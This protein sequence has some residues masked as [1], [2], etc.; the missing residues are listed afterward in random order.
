MI[1]WETWSFS[2]RQ[3][4][5]RSSQISTYTLTARD[6]LIDSRCSPRPIRCGRQSRGGL[7]LEVGQVR[8]GMLDTLPVQCLD[9]SSVGYLPES[10]LAWITHFETTKGLDPAADHSICEE[11]M[12]ILSGWKYLSEGK[13][14]ASI[15]SFCSQYWTTFFLIFALKF[16]FEQGLSSK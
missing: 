3:L 5:F 7:S 2:I 11:V 4:L 9:N 1:D 10:I 12:D 15:Q 8:L 13:E 14:A 6:V 16:S